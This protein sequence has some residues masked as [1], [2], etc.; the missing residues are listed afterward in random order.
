LTALKHAPRVGTLDIV[1]LTVTGG[2]ERTAAA[3]SAL[4]EQA[5]FPFNRLITTISPMRIIEAR[6]C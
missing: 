1:M 2:R 3:F 6:P 4:L 5:H